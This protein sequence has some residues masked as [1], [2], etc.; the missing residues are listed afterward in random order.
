MLVSLHLCHLKHL[1]YSR[2]LSIIHKSWLYKKALG[3]QKSKQFWACQCKQLEN[4]A[5]QEKPVFRHYKIDTR[6]WSLKNSKED[7]HHNCLDFLPE[8]IFWTTLDIQ[9]QAEHC[10]LAELERQGL[11]S[12]KLR[13]LECVGCTKDRRAARNHC[14]ELQMK[15]F[16]EPKGNLEVFKLGSAIVYGSC[17]RPRASVHRPEV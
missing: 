1:F 7:N 15:W 5:R 3:P 12:G 4:W 17:W 6:M 13:Q 14:E 11:E 9:V 2:K 10:N 16:S 8:G